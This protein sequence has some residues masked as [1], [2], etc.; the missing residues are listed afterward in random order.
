MELIGMML[1]RGIIMIWNQHTLHTIYLVTSCIA[2]LCKLT[3]RIVRHDTH[4]IGMIVW[5]FLCVVP[6]AFMMNKHLLDKNKS[7]C[8]YSCT[9]IDYGEH[10]MNYT[11]MSQVEFNAYIKTLKGS[12]AFGV[13]N[14]Y[15]EEYT[16]FSNGFFRDVYFH[17]DRKDQVLVARIIIK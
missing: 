10:E 14:T 7:A 1:F 17:Y 12:V 16:V 5:V 2:V 8:Y 3:G 13:G 9:V 11:P 4:M 15:T 6:V